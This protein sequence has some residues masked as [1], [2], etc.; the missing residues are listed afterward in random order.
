MS[1]FKRKDKPKQVDPGEEKTVRTEGLFVKCPGCEQMLFKR[2]VE[3]NFNVCPKCNYH[4]R[5]GARE[6]LRL[7]FDDEKWI[8]HDAGLASTNPL[9]FVDTK[10]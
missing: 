2:E 3:E 5:I 9:R 10:N 4:N 7:T 8:E 6:R 1:W